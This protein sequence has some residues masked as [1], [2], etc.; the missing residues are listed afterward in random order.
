MYPCSLR[1]P[2]LS[3]TAVQHLAIGLRERT[4]ASTLWRCSAKALLTSALDPVQ[5]LLLEVSCLKPLA[6][7][8]TAGL[9]CQA[10]S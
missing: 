4:S 6:L 10:E 2:S 7:L 1:A 8:V 9:P 5:S 3:E